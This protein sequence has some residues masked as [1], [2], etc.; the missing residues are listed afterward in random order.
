LRK[1]NF[2]VVGIKYVDNYSI[3]VSGGCF[4][5]PWSS[6]CFDNLLYSQHFSGAP[7]SGKIAICDC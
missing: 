5:I 1:F 3:L 2:K 7:R 4:Y 6:C